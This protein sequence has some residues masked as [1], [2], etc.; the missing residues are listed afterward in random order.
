MTVDAEPAPTQATATPSST[1]VGGQPAHTGREGLFRRLWAH[2]N[3]RI[4]LI[5]LSAYLLLAVFGPWL[6]AWSP[7]SDFHYQNL[8]DSMLPPSLD[9]GHLLG[10]DQLGRDELVRLVLGARY[11]LLIGL[12]AV[13]G[14]MVI[15]V[16][17]GGLSGYYKGSVDMA[18]QRFVDTVLAFPHFLLALALVAVFGPGV[19]NL[20]IALALTSFPR[21]VRLVRATVLSIREQPFVESARGLGASQRRILWRHVMPNSITPAITQAPLELASAI[22]T[23]AGLGF[24][25]LG[26]Q[27]PTPEWGSMLGESRDLMFSAPRLVT[28]PGLCIVGA[29]LA[30][31]LLGDGVRDVLDPR[32]SSRRKGPLGGHDE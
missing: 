16:L 17:L 15:G 9:S 30:F 28:F 24:L 18:I 14:G 22:L 1:P 26:V 5:V 12:G 25:G 8:A 2:R 4:G 20:I 31:N 7:T 21:T 11:T 19:R 10:T 6:M 27:A 32:L 13:A 29:I 23:A 3:S